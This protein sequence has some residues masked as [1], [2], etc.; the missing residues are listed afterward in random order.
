MFSFFSNE[1]VVV[2]IAVWGNS[3]GASA[4][5]MGYFFTHTCYQLYFLLSVKIFFSMIASF[6]TTKSYCHFSA[7]RQIMII[8]VLRCVG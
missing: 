4:K 5:E 1:C 8:A 6:G 2:S 3:I 7:G